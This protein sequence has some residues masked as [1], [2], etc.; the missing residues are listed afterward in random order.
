VGA[1][2]DAIRKWSGAKERALAVRG[3]D[4]LGRIGSALALKEVATLSAIV[5]DHGVADEAQGMLE[6][7]AAAQGAT[8]EQIEDQHVN[9]CG[10]DTRGERIFSYGPRSFRAAMGNGLELTLFGEDGNKRVSL[11]PPAATDDRAT[12]EASRATWSEVKTAFGRVLKAQVKRFEQAM[13]TGR[14][15]PLPDFQ[16]HVLRHPIVS[17]IAKTLVWQ[18]ADDASR[19]LRVTEDL[20]FADAAD[21]TASLA[22]S[23]RLRV[24]HPLR[25]SAEELMAWEA[26][27]SDYRILQPFQQLARK[28]YLCEPAMAEETSLAIPPH[29][30]LKPGVLYGILDNDGWRLGRP[31]GGRFFFSS[32]RFN[33][34]GVTAVI[35]FSGLIAGE[36][37]K[38]PEQLLKQ[39]SFHPEDLTDDHKMPG[40]PM[41]LGSVPKAAFSET[42]RRLLRL[43]EEKG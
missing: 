16:A 2:H 1:L 3:L 27:F 22:E 37:G 11:P 9:D 41:P 5:R 19:S 29:A 6:R 13:I 25:L 4:V 33:A 21:E 32:K 40:R 8:R 43:T 36:I 39:C 38:S 7:K 23:P 30:A 12:A 24:A 18:T 10:L 31:V 17:R 34:D 15:W 35:H 28:A 26:L 42:A 14:E 20:S